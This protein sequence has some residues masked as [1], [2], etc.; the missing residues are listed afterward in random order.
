ME[1]LKKI[2][3]NKSQMNPSFFRGLDQFKRLLGNILTPKK[4]F[5][6]GELVTGEGTDFFRNLRRGGHQP[7]LL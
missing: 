3:D 1:L 6:E 2:N 5:N 4:S 7:H